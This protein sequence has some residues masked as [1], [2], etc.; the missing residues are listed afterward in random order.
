M[1]TRRAS[2]DGFTLVESVIALGLL[3]II[4]LG[5]TTSLSAGVRGVLVG[6]ARNGATQLANEVIEQARA[7]RYD[8]VGHD[9]GGDSTLASDP[10]ITTSGTTRTYGGEA[11]VG[12]SLPGTTAPGGLSASPFTPH[13]RTR[14]VDGTAYT[15]RVYVTMV[16]P[17]SGDA[18]KRL[19]VRVSWGPR[20]SAGVTRLSSFLFDAK[21]P[22]DPL[23]KGNNNADSGNLPVTGSLGALNLTEARL[24]LPY[25]HGEID[26]GFIRRAKGFAYGSRS[27]IS[28]ASGSPTA[29][30]LSGGG[31]V[32]D[33]GGVKAETVADNDDGTARAANDLVGPLFDFGGAVSTGG[34]L[35]ITLGT[36]SA[37]S[38]STAR[39][40]FSCFSPSIGDD[41][42]LPYHQSTGAGPSSGSV[43]FAA[44]PVSGSLLSLASSCASTCARS[45]VDVDTVSGNKQ[46]VSTATTST[47]SIDVL[48]LAAGPVGFSGMV[49]AASATATATATAGP[50]AAAPTVTGAAVTLQLYDTTGVLPAYRTVNVTP[51]TAGQWTSHAGLSIGG[52]NVQLDATVTS[53]ASTSSSQSGG[54]ALTHAEASMTDW[55]QISVHMVI[56]TGSSTQ[57]DLTV[58]F[59]Y[60]RVTATSDYTPG[61]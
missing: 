52:A 55:L 27:E 9:L 48:T 6:R 21:N 2:E 12:S 34:P 28:L 43:G 11:L 32:G 30:A 19:S 38:K 26:S 10:A 37:Q 24:W 29:C 25:S 33:C 23:L 5:L 31:M 61:P 45:T 17:V 46:I 44:G 1:L 7:I 3:G 56:Q 18:Y 58:V 15:V 36:G 51:G 20:P 22:P 47:P 40:C 35:S 4:M 60:G 42:T 13:T 49:K 41:D 50:S 14:T 57:A 39:S 8:Q 54:G 53:L 16:T 59:D